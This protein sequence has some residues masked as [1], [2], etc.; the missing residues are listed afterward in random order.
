MTCKKKPLRKTIN[1]KL[2][3]GTIAKVTGRP[4]KAKWQNKGK[5]RKTTKMK[6]PNRHTIS[7]NYVDNVSSSR[8]TVP[9]SD[10]PLK[11]NTP[12]LLSISA[13]AVAPSRSLYV[14]IRVI[15]RPVSFF[16]PIY[17]RY[18]SLSL[19]KRFSSRS[20]APDSVCTIAGVGTDWIDTESMIWRHY[21]WQIAVGLPW[22]DCRYMSQM[23]IGRCWNRW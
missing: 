2:D 6:I 13:I 3:I 1:T 8:V 16:A 7:Q 22:T 18:S 9:Y 19:S 10:W 15:W 4:E 21:N 12:I 14:P 23:C 20:C 5:Y 11:A 17:R